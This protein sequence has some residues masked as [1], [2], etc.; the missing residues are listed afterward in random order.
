MRFVLTGFTHNV[1]FRVFAFDS[2]S[3][4][5]ERTQCTVRADL[6]LARKYGIHVQELP[7]LCRSLLEREEEG[8]PTLSL[9]FTEAEMQDCA[10]GRAAAHDAA[11]S[12][13][14]AP[15][16]RAGENVGAAWR[17]RRP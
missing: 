5:R 6:G 3:E 8:E 17:G 13:R 2:I 12:K 4:E 1:E 15:H 11:A 14:K 16:G 7:L 9:T 10:R